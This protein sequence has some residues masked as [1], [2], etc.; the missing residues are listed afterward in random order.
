MVDEIFDSLVREAVTAV[1]KPAGFRKTA[2]NFHRRRGGCVQVV[3]IQMSGRWVAHEK[4]FYVNVGL[5]FDD[6]CRLTNIPILERLKE[7]QCDERGTRDRLWRLVANGGEDQWRVT[8]RGDAAAIGDHLR[9]AITELVGELELIDGVAAYR[10]HR[11][12]DRF[13]PMET[14]AKVLYILGDY[15]GARREVEDLVTLF[16]ERQNAP[17]ADWFI[18][19]LGLKELK[20]RS[21]G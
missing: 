3:N 19:R 5:A 15:D 13:R 11:W 21:L 8:A 14:N 7:Y 1:L 2:L 4:A 6:I 20:G 17:D 9:L 12:F 10:S 16:A 18:E